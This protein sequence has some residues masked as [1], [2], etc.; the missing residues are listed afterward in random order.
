MKPAIGRRARL[1][2]QAIEGRKPVFQFYAFAQLSELVF[3]D[4]AQHAHRVFAFDLAGGMHKPLGQFAI[5]GEEQQTRSIEI[6]ASNRNPTA[7]FQF[8]QAGKHGRATLR[9]L[10]G[11]NFTD[12][13]TI[14]NGLR[15][16]GGKT[17]STTI[18]AD[19]ISA[20]DLLPEFSLL[21]VDLQTPGANPFFRLAT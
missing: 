13:F 1:L 9:V 14:N 3:S 10:A 17:Q 19:A 18:K 11:H 4:F 20:G 5:C 2:N 16:W 7:G 8:R 21:A 6:Q 15:F 12:T